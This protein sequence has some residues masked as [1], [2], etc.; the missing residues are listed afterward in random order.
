ML[1]VSRRRIVDVDVR[2]FVV[3]GRIVVLAG[4]DGGVE[5]HGGQ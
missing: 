4:E 1:C 2:G 5:R 3:V